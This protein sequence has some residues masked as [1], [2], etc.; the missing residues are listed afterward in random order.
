MVFFPLLQLFIVLFIVSSFSFVE[1][2]VVVV[3]AAAEFG[4]FL[5]LSEINVHAKSSENTISNM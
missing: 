3:A 1:V 2:A 4:F 5:F